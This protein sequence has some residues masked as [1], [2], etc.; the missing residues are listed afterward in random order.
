MQTGHLALKGVGHVG[1]RLVSHLVAGNLLHRTD[2]SSHFLGGTVSHDNCFVEDVVVVGQG[3][4]HIAGN[5][6][7]L[8]LLADV[9]HTQV[10]GGGGHVLKNETAVVAGGGHCLVALNANRSAD[11]GLAGGVDH[12]ARHTLLRRGRRGAQEHR[13]AQKH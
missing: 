13:G 5:A 4:V 2:Y 7:R 11:N 9:G 1:R 3:H 8:G 12:A 6:H 10:T